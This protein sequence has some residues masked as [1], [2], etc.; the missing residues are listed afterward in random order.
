MNT[1]KLALIALFLGASSIVFAQ[2][3]Q[4]NLADLI[5]TVGED[6]DN[7]AAYT[8]EAVRSAP[9]QV[10]DI[11]EALLAAYPDLAEEIIFGAI[12]GMPT[13]LEEE[14]VTRLVERAV[15]FRPALAT[16]IALGARRA[17][18]GMEQVI[19][20]AAVRALR[21]SAARTGIVPGQTRA[22]AVPGV[23]VDVSLLGSDVISPAR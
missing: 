12:A 1:L 14:E 2:I 9:G 11:I 18:T 4:V 20:V 22:H 23:F 5:D 17:T 16:D 13:P 8:E 15:L 7:T 19:N 3:N 6:P 10:H 21:S